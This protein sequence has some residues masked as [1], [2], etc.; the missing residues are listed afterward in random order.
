MC[1]I[2]QV[3]RVNTMHGIGEEAHRCF[4]FFSIE[5]FL[6]ALWFS[7]FSEH[8]MSGL[9]PQVPWATAYGS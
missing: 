1:G 4:T 7:S 2:L 3:F 9:V 6:V 5:L 8:G